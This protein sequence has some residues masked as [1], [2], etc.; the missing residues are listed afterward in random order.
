MC[1]LAAYVGEEVLLSNILIHPINSLVN[2]SMN[3]RESEIR[4]NGDGFG[5][6]WYNPE[7]STDPALFTSISPAWNDRNLLSLADKI[8]SPC[9]FAHVRA[10]SEGGVTQ[11]NCH[12]FV[13]GNWMMMHNGG[14]N[15]F[16]RVKRHI[17]HLLDDDVYNWIKGETDSEH[18][19][20]LFIQMG[21]DRDLTTYNAVANLVSDVFK[22]LDE[23][24]SEFGT[25]GNSYLNICVTD[26]ERIFA[27]RYCSDR[28]FRPESMHYSAGS[29]FGLYKGRYRM[30]QQK[31]GH[32]RCMLITSEKLTNFS[33]QWHRIPR[34]HL[35]MTNRR[36][37][38]DFRAL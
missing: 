18:L 25:P 37:D 6:G 7:I 20:A 29:S 8:K 26:G 21:K 11:Y 27:S 30:R 36:L 17:R 1:R 19:F 16:V 2:Q 31:R 13:Y 35:L 3:A 5:V 32:K 4:T 12:P 14:I 28:R 34:H 24:I 38:I 22:Q 15:D 23:I 9:F 10:A 33:T